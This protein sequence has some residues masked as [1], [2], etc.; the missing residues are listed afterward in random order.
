MF[1]PQM[2]LPLY[3][4][5]Q[6]PAGVPP[7]EDRL[8]E[9]K[10]TLQR[11]VVNISGTAEVVARARKY[12]GFTGNRY[13]YGGGERNGVL[14][15]QHYINVQKTWE[16]I[17]DLGYDSKVEFVDVLRLLGT[18]L[19]YDRYGLVDDTRLLDEALK[20]F[21]PRPT[22]RAMPAMPTT[23]LAARMRTTV[24]ISYLCT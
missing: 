5:T 4:P 19:E 8:F 20:T 7:V 11:V 21:G 18:D 16:H 1:A 24:A 3:Q 23:G 6:V 12:K 14:K 10:D 2:N 9:W 17:K 13:T 15:T 22:V